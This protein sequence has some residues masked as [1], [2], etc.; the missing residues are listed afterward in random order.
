M[1]CGPPAAPCGATDS[2]WE[3]SMRRAMPLPAVAAIVVSMLVS[4][5]SQPEP[6][7][8]PAPVTQ[9]APGYKLVQGYSTPDA[10]QKANDDSDF[11]GLRISASTD[12]SR[13]PSTAAGSRATSRR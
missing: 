10:A 13:P 6:A 8:S 5:C 3:N 12:R 9:A 1:S 4:G 7:A 2:V 11:G